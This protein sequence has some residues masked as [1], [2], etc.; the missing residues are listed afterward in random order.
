MGTERTD[1][2]VNLYRSLLEPPKTFDDGFGWTTVAGIFFC[3]LIMLPGSIYLGLMTGGSLGPAASWVTVILFMEIARRAMKPLKKQHLVVLLHAAGVIMAANVLFPGGPLGHL[4]FRAYLVGSDAV[5]D[6]GMAGSFPS[7]W[8]PPAESDAIVHRTFFHHDWIVP[9]AI[10]AF[11]L[12]LG[13]INRYTLG[14]FFFRLTSDVENL[15]FPLAPVA[16]QGAMALAEAD[17]K[18]SAEEK[19]SDGTARKG[20][21]WRIFSLGAIFGLLY[22]VIQIGIPGITSLF[23]SEPFFLV[24]QPFVDTTV[25]TQGVLPA[26]PTGV[27]LDLGIV[28][29]GFVLPFWAVMGT[30]AAI[31]LTL[32]MNPV[33]HHAGVLT[34][35]QPGMDTVNT[36][37]ANSVDFWLSFGIGAGLGIAV[38]CLVATLRDLRSKMR[39]IRLARANGAERKS[40]W[41]PPRAG[42]GDWSLKLSLGLYV[43]S[44]ASVIALC[45][46]LLPRTPGILFFL[47]IFAFLYNPFISYVNARLLGISGQN[48]DIPFVKEGAF[49]LSGA[50][51]VDI[52]LA[53]VPLD[54]YGYMAQ[55]FRTNEL[56]GVSF[57][58]LLK[59]EL[60]A[61]PVLLILSIFFWNFIWKSETIPSPVFPAAQV[62]WE[63]AAKN[64]VLLFS[65][66]FVAAENEGL[67]RSVEDTEFMRA[68]HPNQIGVGFLGTI[69][70]YGIF[71]YFGLPVMF[72]Y[73][74]IRGFGQLPHFMILEFFGAILGR[75]YLQ[76]KFGRDKFLTLTPALLAGYF[77]GIGLISMVTMAMMLIKSAIS[78][79]PF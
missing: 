41:Q 17:D 22:G 37:F 64:Q 33:L 26:T 30:F 44:S 58:S 68:I 34:H 52:W 32:L 39:E 47:I 10:A 29:L 21:R 5:R 28:F 62:N 18:K 71:S 53:P 11:L 77:T 66:T 31:V 78:S 63:L 56:T 75:F 51:G 73:G 35:W 61:L 40:V 2:E 7:W 14:Y 16:A 69:G 3:G 65:S 15:P 49:I 27:T 76:R 38:V 4:V 72:I 50:R 60:V 13:L 36:T 45:Y 67:D 59:T 23:L 42:R 57:R 1:K 19:N 48:V 43:L 70:L 55:A 54:N 8:V 6:A 46:A 12:F 79:A 20:T 24:P 25:L 9:L 74:L